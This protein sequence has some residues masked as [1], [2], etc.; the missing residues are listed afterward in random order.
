MMLNEREATQL[1]QRL[2]RG[3]T[4]TSLTLTEAEL[5]LEA[6]PWESPLRLRYSVELDELRAMQQAPQPP[7]ER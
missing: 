2:F 7:A 4:V 1:W 5:V 3:Q 6:M